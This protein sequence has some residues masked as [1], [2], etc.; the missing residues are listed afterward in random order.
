MPANARVVDFCRT[1]RVG[2]LEPPPGTVKLELDGFALE[3][4]RQH[5]ESRF[6]PVHPRHTAI[7]APNQP[8]PGRDLLRIGGQPRQRRLKQARRHP[9]LPGTALRYY[10]RF[11]AKRCRVQP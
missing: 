1:E 11:I 2:M 5:L 10:I 7:R 8:D 9:R 6:G 4:S 3:Q